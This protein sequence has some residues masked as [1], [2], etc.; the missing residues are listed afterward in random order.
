MKRS[1]LLRL[2][3]ILMVVFMLPMTPALA[4]A[5]SDTSTNARTYTVMVGAEK[6]NRGIDIE[7]FF[8]ATLHIHVGDSVLWKVNSNEIHTVTFLAGQPAPAL[9]VP[10]PNAPAGAMMINPLAAFPAG[11]A[12]GQY[13][14]S[15]YANSG[16]M[17][18]QPGN[19]LQFKLTFTQAGTFAYGC[20]VHGVTLMAG[21]IVVEPASKNIP[22]PQQAKAQGLRELAAQW[23]KAAAVWNAAVA[24]EKAN[25][26]NADGTTTHYVMIGF[27]KGQVDLMAFFPRITRVKPGD[28]I[29]W[30][31]SP[32][33][34]APHTVTF[35]NGA[36][37]PDLILP[38][39]QAGGPPLLTLNPAVALPL[40]ADQPLTRAVMISSGIIDPSAPGDHTFTLKVGSVSGPIPFLCL[41]HDTSGMKGVVVVSG[42]SSH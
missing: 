1:I 42:K 8:P 17:S 22:S 35:L 40:N 36:S 38:I 10:V 7:A 19:A 32:S 30:Q 39:Q 14:G 3:T 5:G 23:A 29:V 6:S 20:L 25:T 24:S 2:V 9:L 13:D 15:T 21:T 4:A 33:N 31:L 34:M 41:L 11:P 28:T 37:E 18:R 27:A 26:T 12:D 16:I